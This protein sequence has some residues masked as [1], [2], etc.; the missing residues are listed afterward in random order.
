LESFSAR[1]VAMVRFLPHRF[2]C[3]LNRSGYSDYTMSDINNGHGD[4]AAR[5]TIPVTMSVLKLSY[6]ALLLVPCSDLIHVLS[7]LCL[8]KYVSASMMLFS[9]IKLTWKLPNNLTIYPPKLVQNS[10]PLAKTLFP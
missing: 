2:V 10:S 6:F 7:L 4:A 1:L 3:L 9:V 8:I 5:V